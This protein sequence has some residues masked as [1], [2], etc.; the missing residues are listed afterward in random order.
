MTRLA[1]LGVARALAVGAGAATL[2]LASASPVVA[3][4]KDHPQRAAQ[5]QATLAAVPP[6]MSNNMK[7]L[8]TF[9]E[10]AGISGDYA[11][12][13][14]HFY[15]STT[16]GITVLDI[17]NP[18]QPVPK[19]KYVNNYFENE[20]MNYGERRTDRKVT[21]QFVLI[22]VDLQSVDP[23]DPA[24]T[25][26]GGGELIVVDVTNPDNPH[27]RSR[28]DVSTSTH[29]VS[30]V[31]EIQCR[32]A[33]TAGSK[34]GFSII[35]LRDLDNPKEVDS[36]PTTPDVID[37][38]ES[39]ASGPNAVFTRG[40]GHK[41]NFDRG[42]IGFHTGSGGTAAFDVSNPADPQL[43][44]T[45]GAAGR[46]EVER[47]K[48]W[49]NFI[50]HN[51]WHPHHNK[52]RPNAPAALKNGNV[53]LI[54]E[55]DYEQTDCA[56]AGSFQTWKIDGFGRPSAIDPL[57]KVELADLGGPTEFVLPQG[58]FCSAHWFDYHQ[59][60]IVAVG[61][62][63]GGV[64]LLDVRDPKDIKPYGYAV[65]GET[66]DAYWLPQRRAN[67][68]AELPRTNILYQVDLINGLTVYRVDLP[69]GNAAQRAT[70]AGA[71]QTSLPTL[72][73]HSCGTQMAG[74]L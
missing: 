46:G 49:N 27:K 66:W 50:H 31:R 57:D 74:A 23:L 30:C 59:S 51:S 1:R 62:Y 6:L 10:L 38:F 48:G 58:A 61:Y 24:H 71:T 13:T 34:S 68:T 18:A 8:G 3:H 5:H 39:P 29:T 37:P 47:Y 33:Y 4:D 53:L 2:A 42:A 19:G 55:E 16:N 21:D 63:G 41:W 64:R 35:D 45:T 44:T 11:I 60:G 25:N 36:D 73:N 9:P 17:S 14:K 40:A 56:K 69:G 7:L 20:A 12:S 26:I 52:F 32:Y 28:I 54:T 65:G 22:G 70:T 67:G 72:M 15:L 43:L